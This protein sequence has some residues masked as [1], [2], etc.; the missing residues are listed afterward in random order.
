M[1]ITK[2]KIKNASYVCG[3]CGRL[4]G[5]EPKNDSIITMSE[6]NC[7]IC[8]KLKVLCHI[9]NYNYLHKYKSKEE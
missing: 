4:Y 6:D 2:T 9:R 8:G 3:E 5:E 7:D 1:K